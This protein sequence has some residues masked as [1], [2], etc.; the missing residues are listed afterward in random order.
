MQ[1]TTYRSV[2]LSRSSCAERSVLGSS[3]SKSSAWVATLH[4]TS[5]AFAAATGR[6]VS[7]VCDVDEFRC[8][9]NVD[10]PTR[11][12]KV[13]HLH[14]RAA[15][16][17]RPVL[18]TMWCLSVPSSHSKT[19]ASQWPLQTTSLMP[20]ATRRLPS[21]TKESCQVMVP[22]LWPFVGMVW[23]ALASSSRLPLELVH[24][25]RFRVAL[26]WLP[27]LLSEVPGPLVRVFEVTAS[28]APKGNNIATGVWP[29]GSAGVL[30]GRP[31]SVA[32]YITLLT[33]NDFRKF[34]AMLARPS[35]TLGKLS[36]S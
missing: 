33:K 31:K 34:R 24:C 28:W 25:R 36:P 17:R 9:I 2:R 21:C 18:V 35:A 22:T 26:W 5:V 20:C 15:G 19:R 12:E 32:W 10:D 4:P 1:S 16:H 14:S 29:W 23:A 6:V 30:F 7:S 13:A 8:E 11:R 3:S 27:A